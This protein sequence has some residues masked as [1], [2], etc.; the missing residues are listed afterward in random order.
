MP[1]EQEACPEDLPEQAQ[2][3][4][5]VHATTDGSVDP[6]PTQQNKLPTH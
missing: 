6:S 4:T 2:Q 5:I 1:D 3:Y